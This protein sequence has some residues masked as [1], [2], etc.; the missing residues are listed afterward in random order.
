MGKFRTILWPTMLIW[1][2]SAPCSAL[3]FSPPT[4]VTDRHVKD[5]RFLCDEFGRCWETRSAP[6]IHRSPRPCAPMRASKPSAY[7]IFRAG[8]NRGPPLCL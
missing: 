2:M 8:P 1:L 3:Q 5:A 6:Y 4:M 7:K